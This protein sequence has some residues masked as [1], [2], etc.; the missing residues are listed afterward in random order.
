[1]RRESINVNNG[2]YIEDD[3]E[4]EEVLEEAEEE[5]DP[6]SSKKAQAARGTQ[7]L[8]S[9]DR[10]AQLSERKKSL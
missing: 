8:R 6:T 7:F 4:A 3:D 2:D 10:V 1:M 5:D 9:R